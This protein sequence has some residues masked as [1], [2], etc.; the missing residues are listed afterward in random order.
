MLQFDVKE[1]ST[2]SLRNTMTLVRFSGHE[3]GASRNSDEATRAAMLATKAVGDVGAFRKK[4]MASHD[5]EVKQVRRVLRAARESHYSLTR[6]YSN[7]VATIANVH[8]MDYLKKMAEHKK[9]LSKVKQALLLKLPE[10]IAAAMTQLGDM[11]NPGDYPDPETIVSKFSM[12]FEFSPLPATSLAGSE[13]LPPGF[14]ERMQ[15]ALMD[16]VRYQL[17]YG[18]ESGWKDVYD[19]IEHLVIVVGN[20]ETVRYRGSLIGNI[21]TAVKLVEA[22]NLTDNP[23]YDQLIGFIKK[24]LLSRSVGDLRND[25]DYRENVLSNASKVMKLIRRELKM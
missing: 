3:W 25:P 20:P 11:A 14:A 21:A 12:E 8:M 4:L 2:E 15:A 16:R 5:V 13:T 6:P 9:E 23:Q 17:K 19:A 7:G 18:L 22:W 10:R 24:A 1:L